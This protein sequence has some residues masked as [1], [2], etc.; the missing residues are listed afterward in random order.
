MR[1]RGT[2]VQKVFLG[3]I[4]L[5]ALAW[6]LAHAAEIRGVSVNT[7]STGTRAELQLDRASE[8]NVISLANP[9]RL[10]IDL[11]QSRLAAGVRLPAGAGIVRGVRNGQPVPGTA[12]IVFDLADPVV[13]LAPRIEQTAAGPR[14]VIE[15]PG[16]GPAVVASSA[17]PASTLAGPVPTPASQP[18]PAP[19]TPATV[20]SSAAPVAAVVQQAA[21]TA[22]PRSI[23]EGRTVA[24]S[25]QAAAVPAASSPGSI[26]ESV[27]NNPVAASEPA[28]AAPTAAAS[29]RPVASQPAATPAA[30]AASPAA[31]P[32][33]RLRNTGMRPLIV[34]IDAGHGGQDPG[35]V[36]PNGVREKDVT[37]RIARELARQ[38]D[39]TPGLQAYLVRNADEFVPLGQRAARARRAKAD[40][41]LSIHADAAENRS[42]RGGSVYV[43]SLRGASSQRARW[44]A[45]K[46][47]AADLIGGRGPISTD[48]TLNSVLLDLTQSGNLKASEDAA[49][50][51]LDSMSGVGTIRRVERANF[52][53]LRTAHMPAMLVETAFIS[54]PE[55]ER[56][57]AD[58]AFQRRMAGAILQG[59]HTY[60]SAQPPPG[61]MYAARAEASTVAN[62][63]SR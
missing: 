54:N 8:F 37:L 44:L 45:D 6:N 31:Q 53:V 2:T 48:D 22:N 29:V 11:P 17:V 5:F 9:H 12:R 52:A 57:L 30:V 15:W 47:N 33:L 51:V 28:A 36:G 21:A 7:G 32:A 1:A 49:R 4:L 13:A 40:I 63:G 38:V 10:V 43:L 26:L 18:G 39:A 24:G 14:L 42:A 34:A 60:F 25:A 27:S 3:L 46:E 58:P 19:A 41:F 61:T 20:S 23:L 50:H 16:D 59:V 62:T 55:E 35:A 56:R